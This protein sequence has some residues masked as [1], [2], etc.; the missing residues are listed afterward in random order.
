MSPSR[1]ASSSHPVEQAGA[2]EGVTQL[3]VVTIWA[4]Q[5][6]VLPD[7]R[8]EYVGIL[9]AEADRAPDLVARNVSDIHAAKVI[10]TRV[11]LDETQ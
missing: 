8:I 1:L 6:K 10:R 3:I 2:P 11:Q 5:T 9:R 7:G 4:G